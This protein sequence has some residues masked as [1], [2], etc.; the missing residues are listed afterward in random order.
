VSTLII[1]PAGGWRNLRL[2]ELWEYRELLLFLVWKDIKVR[3]KQTAVG[4]AWAI[5][6][7]LLSMLI[8]TVFFGK[9]ARIPSDNIPYPIFSYTALI[10]WTYFA[11]S[12]TSGVESVVAYRQVITKVYFPRIFLPLTP[13]IRG[14][15]DFVIAFVLLLLLM[16]FYHITPT[17]AIWTTPLFLLLAILTSAGVGLWLAALNVTYRDIQYVTPFLVQAW[18][19][20]TPIAYPSSLVPAR[21]RPLYGLN[22]MVGVIEGFRWALLGKSRP[23][24]SMLGVSTAIVI[25]ILV[26]G[27]V[28][29]RNTERSFADVV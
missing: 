3:Y 11:G 12:L 22:P 9:L 1:K 21:W 6:Q 14:L 19:F 5:I 17:P 27:F 18:L 7:P 4:A 23:D 26:S 15:L 25:L 20:A 24:F 8:F 10:V 13:V 2:K 28:F 16:V 29:F